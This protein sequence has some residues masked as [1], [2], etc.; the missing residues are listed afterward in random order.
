[1]GSQNRRRL[2]KLEPFCRIV[3]HT[4]E[5]VR[6]IL[7]AL[8]TVEE[9]VQMSNS[10]KCAFSVVVTIE[11]KRFLDSGVSLVECPDFART[12]TLSSRHGVLRFPS[13]DK[14]KTPTLVT[15]Q[16]WAMGKTIWEVV[17][18]ERK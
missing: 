2:D 17:G 11:P 6:E 5:E 3:E 1:M 16:R 15:S 9:Q 7:A 14:R 10:S 8:E 4:S 18:G 12:C 13:H